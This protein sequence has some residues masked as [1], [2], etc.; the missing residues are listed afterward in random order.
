MKTFKPILFSNE[1]VAIKDLPNKPYLA[2]LKLDGIRCIFILGEMKSRSLKPIQNKQLQEKFK[3]IKEYSMMESLFLDGELYSHNRTFQEISRAVMTQDFEDEKTRRNIITELI[4]ENK[5]IINDDLKKSIE[6]ILYDP[7]KSIPIKIFNEIIKTDALIQYKNYYTS[8]IDD[9]KFYCFDTIDLNNLD[10]PFANRLDSIPT[11]LPHIIKVKQLLVTEKFEIEQLFDT[12]LKKGYEGLMLRCPL[13][14]YK[15][16]RVTTKS[17]DG[18]KIKPYQ[19]F[20]AKIIGFVQAT[21]VKEGTVR[22]KNELGYSETS[23]KKDDRVLVPKLVAF[24][25]NYNGLEQKVVYAATDE[26]KEEAW[27]NRFNLHGKW[28]EFKGM[29]VGSKDLIRHP[30]WQRFRENDDKGDE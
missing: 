26:E 3:E 9:I 30:V 20:D 4:R 1:Q 2:S 19:T 17:E 23:K 21:V 28:I 16:G 7:E 10:E 18:Y 8:L 15:F 24:L 5:I 22:T 12:A 6:K 14:K 13:S 11:T 29:L 27:K 25:V